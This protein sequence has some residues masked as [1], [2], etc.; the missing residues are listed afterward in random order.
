MATNSKLEVTQG[1]RSCVQVRKGER[2]FRYLYE[3]GQWQRLQSTG[4]TEC[5]QDELFAS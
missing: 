4:W 3:T 5:R 2:L 1:D